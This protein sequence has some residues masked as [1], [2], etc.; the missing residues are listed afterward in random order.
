MQTTIVAVIVLLATIFVGWTLTP[1][2]WRLRAL[3]K[4]L[5]TGWF[6]GATALGRWLA[7]RTARERTRSGAACGSCSV[8]PTRKH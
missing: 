8:A 2:A 6:D 3:D 7:A 5:A 4:L 1:V